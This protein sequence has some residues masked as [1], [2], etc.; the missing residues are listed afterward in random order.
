[1]YY[2]C[3]ACD[4]EDI[5]E[6]DHTCKDGKS[7]S[8]FDDKGR[9]LAQWGS[10]AALPDPPREDV[11]TYSNVLSGPRWSGLNHALKQTAYIHRLR[12]DEYDEDKG[13]LRTSVYFRVAGTLENIKAFIT[14]MSQAVK[15]YNK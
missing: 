2:D 6:R 5:T 12:F 1:M 14:D 7:G 13:W 15:D 9:L 3:P 4:Q 11:Y 10:A 8:L